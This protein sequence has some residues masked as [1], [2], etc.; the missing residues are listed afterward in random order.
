MV[1]NDQRTLI[2]MARYPQAG[3][4]TRLAA[5]VGI[6]KA[7]SIYRELLD[8]TLEEV[9]ICTARGVRVELHVSPAESTEAM[10]AYTAL[11]VY[12]QVEGDI[13]DRMLTALEEAKARGAGSLVVIGSDCPY[14][15]ASHLEEAFSALEEQNTVLGPSMD[16]GYYL[17]GMQEPRKEMFD[18]IDWSTDKVLYQTLTALASHGLSCRLLET[19][20]DVDELDAWLRYRRQEQPGGGFE[21]VSALPLGPLSVEN[22]KPVPDEPLSA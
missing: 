14:I 2:L 15:S 18:Q 9:R 5:S 3:V 10:A 21:L 7:V 19:L 12:S 22:H 17:L 20:E 8:R 4:K 6:E 13:G 1:H 16:G 11:P